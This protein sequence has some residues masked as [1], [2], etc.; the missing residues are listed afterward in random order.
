M[1]DLFLGVLQEKPVTWGRDN[2]IVAIGPWHRFAYSVAARS[3]SFPRPL[4]PPVEGPLA[5]GT[6]RM[7]A[8]AVAHPPCAPIARSQQRTA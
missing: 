6:R 3:S 5:T 2:L 8:A 4:K 7:G 1:S